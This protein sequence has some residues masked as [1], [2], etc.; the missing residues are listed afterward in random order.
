M[1]TTPKYF[2]PRCN[3]VRYEAGPLTTSCSPLLII[4]SLRHFNTQ[5]NM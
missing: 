1:D 4:S 2:Q 5:Q 3:A